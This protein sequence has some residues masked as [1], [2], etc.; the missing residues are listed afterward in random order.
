MPAEEIRVRGTVQGVGFRPTVWRLARECGVTGEVLNDADGVLIR[1]YGESAALES[2]ARRL[3]RESPP[4]ARIDAISR[5]ACEWPGAAPDEFTIVASVAGKANTSVAADAATCPECIADISD[6]GNRRYR[7]PFTNCTHCGPRLS[8]V[9]S[10]PYDRPRTSMKAFPMCPACETEYRDPADRRFHAQPNAC[11]ECGPRA[12]LEDRSGQPVATGDCEDAVS[13]AADRIAAG[14][15]VAIKGI[16][17]FH[18]ACDATNADAVTKLR[19][20]KHRYAKALAMMARDADV[21][22]RYARLTAEELALLETAAAPIVVLEAA[23]KP[24]PD[25]IAPG[26]DTLG[27]MLPYTPLHHLL[28]AD[29]DRPIVLTSGNLSDEPQVIDNDV[30]R[31]RLGRIA[32]SFLMHDREIVNRLDDSVVAVVDGE[33]N[34]LRRAR[35][36]APD[37]VPMPAGF[38][39]ADGLLAMGG[40]LKN[41]FCLVSHGKAIVSQHIGDMEEATALL[42]AER[43]LDLYQR[44][45]AF[46]PSLVAVD[47]HPEYLPTKQARLAFDES[48]IVDVQHHHAHVAAC[49]VE[50]GISLD[51][52]PVLAIVL[53]GLGWGDDD[54]LWGGEF[55]VADYRG[56]ARVAHFLPVALPG[57]ARAM[58]EPWRNTWSHLDAAFGWD[59][60]RTRYAD[61]ECMRW[62][63]GQPVDTLATMLDRG[64]NSPLAS[65]AGRLFDAVAGVLG[66]CRERMSHEAEAAMALETLARPAMPGVSTDAYAVDVSETPVRVLSFASL[67]RALLAD[68]QAGIDAS[69]IAARF[70]A[71]IA[72]ALV[73]AGTREAT[74]R[75]LSRV[76]LTGGVFQNAILQSRVRSA[77]LNAGFEVLVPRNYPANDG[78]ISLGQAAIA[79]ARQMPVST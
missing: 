1:A 66:I 43:N 59:H 12:W 32:D 24:L 27:F 60:V 4:L 19:S 6:P 8:I 78:G 40:E 55:L 73:E 5:A 3:E 76:V 56:Y 72:N 9:E 68:L 35:G 31:S 17:G 47:R 23:G 50:H 53:D 41:T 75:D 44:L 20:R 69:V 63:E 57:G 10:I 49:L 62:F 18:L 16:G 77:L 2:L 71:G 37:P 51:S 65:S 70:H 58:R 14:Q 67:W 28:M 15:I 26:Q 33:T 61:L 42:D 74:R 79:V 52:E 36:Y 45:F 22:S 7:Y 25:A 13:A 48:R 11:P 54:A 29:L 21:I 30:A 64:L 38:E 46:E 34:V 39:S